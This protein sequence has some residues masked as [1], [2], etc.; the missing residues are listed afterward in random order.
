MTAAKICPVPGCGAAIK[1]RGYLMCWE[2]WKRTPLQ[3]RRA[4]HRTW[5]VVASGARSGKNGD[6]R[7][8]DILAYHAAVEVAVKASEAAR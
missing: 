8:D 1:R 6:E 3:P 2:C 4:V 7:L 5:R